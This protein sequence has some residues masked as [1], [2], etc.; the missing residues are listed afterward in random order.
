MFI[1]FG[2]TE[3]AGSGTNWGTVVLG[4]GCSGQNGYGYSSAVRWVPHTF[5]MMVY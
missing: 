2:D 4:K 5:W 3:V 1:G